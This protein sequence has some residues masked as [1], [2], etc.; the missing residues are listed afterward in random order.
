[1][2]SFKFALNQSVIISVS[3]ETGTVTGRCNYLDGPD[4]Y[5]VRYKAADGRA[6]E[7]WWS[8]SALS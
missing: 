8:E 2:N 3:G 7:S 5:L 4:T 6:C 1:M